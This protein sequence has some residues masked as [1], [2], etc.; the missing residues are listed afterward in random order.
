MVY[1]EMCVSGPPEMQPSASNTSADSSTDGLRHRLS[2]I[3]LSDT[4]NSSSQS[5]N[6]AASGQFPTPDPRATWAAAMVQQQPFVP[7]DGY[8]PNYMVQQLMWMQ[9]AYAH[10][11][12]QYM[13]M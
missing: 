6:N 12:T 2:T 3:H 7:A 10:Y 9:Q 8:D 4:P 5:L 11:M 13:Q 1:T